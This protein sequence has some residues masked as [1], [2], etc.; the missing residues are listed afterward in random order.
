MSDETVLDERWTKVFMDFRGIVFANEM[1]QTVSNILG[2]I[3]EV[4]YGLQDGSIKINNRYSS[5]YPG[6]LFHGMPYKI[7]DNEIYTI[8]FICKFPN[9]ETEYPYPL[10]LQILSYSPDYNKD[11]GDFFLIKNTQNKE[12]VEGEE[13]ECKNKFWDI[14]IWKGNDFSSKKKK[15]AFLKICCAA[16]KCPVK[17]C[18]K[19]YSEQEI[20]N[21]MKKLSKKTKH[22]KHI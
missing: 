17:E 11:Y 19:E 10:L 15:R 2:K 12:N 21:H 8:Q 1:N 14:E 4:Y 6:F 16:K 9:G 13:R 3:N 22:K 18:K 7:S 20:L 5:D